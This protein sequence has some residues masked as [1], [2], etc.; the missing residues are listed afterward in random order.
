MKR[1]YNLIISLVLAFTV[2]CFAT[3]CDFSLEGAGGAIQPG[4]SA[5]DIA[6]AEFNAQKALVE[7]AKNST[8]YDEAGNITAEVYTQ[9]SIKAMEEALGEFAA[10][11]PITKT[12]EQIYEAVQAYKDALAKLVTYEKY[13]LEFSKIT[14]KMREFA[15][16]S[17]EAGKQ[18]Y[19]NNSFKKFQE[20]WE[21][22]ASY[23][24]LGKT[25]VELA[26]MVKTYGS[27]FDLLVT[28]DADIDSR[29]QFAI[30]Q[31]KLYAISEITGDIKFV[32]W[33][34]EIKKDWVECGPE[35]E[36]A[37][38][39][40]DKGV[41]S[42]VY[43]NDTNS[44]V[45]NISAGAEKTL[46]QVFVATDILTIF[47]RSFKDIKS[48]SV[49]MNVFATE[50]AEERT[51]ETLTIET[52]GEGGSG[53]ALALALLAI[54]VGEEQVLWD[55]YELKIPDGFNLVLNK[56]YAATFSAI[57]GKS[58]TAT[59]LFSNSNYEYESTF[60]VYFSEIPQTPTY[61]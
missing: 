45:F 61:N 42:I 10:F 50:D 29:L 19:T 52:G 4:L 43:D 48:I 47:D 49:D 57:E 11:S 21:S 35:D 2:A 41:D 20:A 55:Y 14:E 36:G 40:P 13:F 7:D 27:F 34:D 30:T 58:C 44:A 51:N 24:P 53:M 16:T 17:Q 18:T 28:C 3:A 8:T 23:D 54:C 60:T 25:S 26:E 33:D 22:V 12:V 6:A 39:V 56:I 31:L 38:V 15:E 9:A 37:R 46:L 1:F 32:R 59:V 5:T